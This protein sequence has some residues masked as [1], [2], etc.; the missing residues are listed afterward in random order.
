MTWVSNKHPVSDYG[1]G[2]IARGYW[3]QDGASPLSRH[4]GGQPFLCS[5]CGPRGLSWEVIPVS[6]P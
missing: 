6:H 1:K 5:I 4:G 3:S 2:G